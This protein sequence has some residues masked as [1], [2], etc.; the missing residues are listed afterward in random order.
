M[1]EILVLCNGSCSCN[2]IQVWA[3]VRTRAAAGNGAARSAAAATT[4]RCNIRTILCRASSCVAGH[5]RTRPLVR[6]RYVSICY[7]YFPCFIVSGVAGDI[8]ACRD[9]DDAPLISGSGTR[10][11]SHTAIGWSMDTLLESY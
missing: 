1:F 2:N 6:Y 5:D 10:A 4:N 7:W 8:A 3:G 9:G 11:Q